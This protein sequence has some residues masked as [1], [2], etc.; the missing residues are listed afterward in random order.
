VKKFGVSALKK[1]SNRTNAR[2]STGPKSGDGKTRSARNAFR[3]G[4]NQS[5]GSDPIFSEDVKVLAR[6]IAGADASS[7]LLELAREIAEAQIDLRRVRNAR[8]YLFSS[9]LDDPVYESRAGVRERRAR[10]NTVERAAR[11][12]RPVPLELIM[13]VEKLLDPAP[14][15]SLKYVTILIDMAQS[16]SALDRYERRAL[17]RRKF[18]IRAFDAA[19][20]QRG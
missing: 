7:E 8:H 20:G 12:V 16:F 13:T 9:K 10:F 19:R 3:H 17:S 14:L 1:A 11:G 18:A 5:V 15:G 6:E 2:A 4:L